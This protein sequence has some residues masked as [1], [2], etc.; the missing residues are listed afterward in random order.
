MTLGAMG[1][2]MA[3]ISLWTFKTLGAL[4]GLGWTVFRSSFSSVCCSLSM[5]LPCFFF[6][7]FKGLITPL[8]AL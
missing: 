1:A 4:G 6:F 2:R 8:E 7:L 3:G 5:A